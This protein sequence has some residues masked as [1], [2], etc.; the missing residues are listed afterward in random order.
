MSFDEEEVGVTTRG[1]RTKNYV[2]EPKRITRSRAH[3]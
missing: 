3:K 1:V 2:E